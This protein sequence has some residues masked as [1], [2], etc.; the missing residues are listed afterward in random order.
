MAKPITT[1]EPAKKNVNARPEA[2]TYNP[3]KV[4]KDSR[5]MGK[6]LPDGSKDGAAHNGEILYGPPDNGHRPMKNMK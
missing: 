2:P 5:D 6:R 1:K 3:A 4:V